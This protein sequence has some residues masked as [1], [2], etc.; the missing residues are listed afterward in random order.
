MDRRYASVFGKATINLRDEVNRRIG[1]IGRIAKN[2]L[3][4]DSLA[5]STSVAPCPH[6]DHNAAGIGTLNTREL[7]QRAGP[8]GIGDLRLGESRGAAHFG[9]PA[10]GF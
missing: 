8:A 1:C 3:D 5:N 10:D 7:R 4:K 9:R 6:D 2:W